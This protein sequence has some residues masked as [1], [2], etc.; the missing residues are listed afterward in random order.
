MAQDN[1]PQI[2]RVSVR[3]PAFMPAEPELWFAIV[4]RNFEVS[5]VS[6]ET[7][8]FGY[9]LSALDPKHVIEVK[10]IALSPPSHEPYKK[11]KEELIKRLSSSQEERTRRLLEHEAIGD[12]KPS[13]FLRHLRD[14]GGSAVSESVVRTLWLGRLPS[15][16][17][18]I[19][20]T[21][22][23][24]SLDQVADLADAVHEATK[25]TTP[26]IAETQSPSLEAQVQ[27]QLAQLTLHLREELASI[28]Q[29]VSAIRDNRPP[30]S[31]RPRSRSTS[32][33][34]SRSR[35]PPA[36]GVC[37]YHWQF[38]N[39][40]NKCKHPCNFAGNATNGH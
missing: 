22:K 19:L 29:E 16:L 12:R 13:Q 20:A 6:A 18:A 23:N 37:W 34:R 10:D 36:S 32:R 5:G 14:L 27:I 8:K 28:R 9:I 39:R 2:D 31:H 11:L 17:Q 24:S 40:A 21:Q 1:S 7:T 26:C 33:R 15:S 3:L 30:E 35:E 38:G 25:I 4:E